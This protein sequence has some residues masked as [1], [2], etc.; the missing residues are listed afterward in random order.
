MKHLFSFTTLIVCALAGSAHAVVVKAFDVEAL[1]ARA[2]DVVAAKGKVHKLSFVMQNFQ[3]A[4]ELDHE[5]IDNCSFHCMTED[6]GVSMCVH[7]AYRDHYLEGGVGYPAHY[8]KLRVKDGYHEIE[9]GR[10][11][12]VAAK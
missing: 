10:P 12:P 7:N 2:S 4:S 8:K 1:T 11:E 3:D 5:R 9:A 6:G